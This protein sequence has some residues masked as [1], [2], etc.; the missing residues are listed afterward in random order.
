MIEP[1]KIDREQKK[2]SIISSTINCWMILN[3]TL[4]A[5]Y[6][7]NIENINRELFEI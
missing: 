5:I 2:K 3:Y 6:A 7:Y 1:N 4:A